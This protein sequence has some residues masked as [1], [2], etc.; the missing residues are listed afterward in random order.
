M[1][2]KRAMPLLLG[3]LLC[4]PARCLAADPPDACSAA[5][6]CYARL[7]ASNAAELRVS[8]V[9]GFA[10]LK[11]SRAEASLLRLAQD[12]S[13]DVRRELAWALGRLGRAGSVPVLCDLLHDPDA[14]A[15]AQARASLDVLTQDPGLPEEQLRAIEPA[16]R[17]A[18]LLAA[19]AGA[20]PAARLTAL[21]AL[22]CFGDG[23]A[24]AAVLAFL[25]GASP[26]PGAPEQIAAIEVLE[27][28]GTRAAVPWLASVAEARPEAAWALGEIGGPE[29]EEALLRGLARF[30]AYEQ[31]HVLNLDRL[32]STRCGPFTGSLINSVGCI[33]YRGQ[34]EDLCYDPTPLQRACANLVR[35]A[36]RADEVVELVLRELERRGVEEEIPQDLRDPIVR[37][38]E[39]LAPGFVRNDGW[40]TSQPLSAMA[41]LV[42]DRRLAPRLIALLDHPA[43]VARVYV[44]IALG[45]LGAVEAVPALLDQVEQGYPFEDPV[46]PVS[47]KHFGDS[48]TV[49]WKGFLCMALGRVGGEESRLALE[50]LAR[51]PAQ[52]RDIRFGAV[53]GLGF[54]AA[55]ESL[56][57]LRAVAEGDLVD[58]IRQEAAAAI[59]RIEL[60]GADRR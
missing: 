29:A 45:R 5:F 42:E 48:Q 8:G 55:P 11:T 34:P 40:V 19:L 31:A 25:A 17:E 28:V 39:E 50:R 54:L 46:T 33:S 7:I 6:E 56:P 35:R 18:E 57:T 32:H 26:P 47:G 60:E 44:A 22:R 49:R 53:V 3:V 16:A 9:Q 23:S 14:G 15:R 38:R 43:F 1:R 21:R 13:A 30:G 51:D 52:Y 4:A 10:W 24:E 58:R 20:D 41:L 59:H 12:P 37:L 2:A 27:R 36:G